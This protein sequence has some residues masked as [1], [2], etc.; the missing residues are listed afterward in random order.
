MEKNKSPDAYFA[1]PRPWREELNALRK[2]LLASGLTEE[3]KWGG[4][5]YTLDGKNVVG[6]GGFIAL[7]IGVAITALLVRRQAPDATPSA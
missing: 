7:A 4:P 6:I 2:I 1:K 3:I 5:C